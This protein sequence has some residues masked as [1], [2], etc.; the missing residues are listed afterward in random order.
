M[1]LTPNCPDCGR[2]VP[3]RQTQLGLG[4]PFACKRCGRELVIE[5]N[6]WIPMAGIVAFWL[7]KGQTTSGLQL[8]GLLAASLAAIWLVSL[9]FMPVE[10]FDR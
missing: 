10:R 2:A 3:F 6:Y 8:A 7:L 9:L 5:K 1:A 4:R